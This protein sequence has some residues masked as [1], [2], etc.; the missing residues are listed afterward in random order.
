MTQ[1]FYH[2]YKCNHC[3]QVYAGYELQ[4]Y[5]HHLCPE[6]EGTHFDGLHTSHFHPGNGLSLI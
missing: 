6:C 4:V 5:F 1:S 3:G 2:K